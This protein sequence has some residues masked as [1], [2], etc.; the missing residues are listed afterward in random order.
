MLSELLKCSLILLFHRVFAWLILVM[1]SSFWMAPYRLT[2]ADQDR[3]RVLILTDI[4]SL[5]TG[6]AEPDDGQS[7][8][9]LLLYANELQIEGLI[10]S[11]NLGHGQQVRPD[12]I[13]QVIEAYGKVQPNLVKHSPAYPSA[14]HLHQLVKAGQLIAGPKIP[15]T[16]SIGLGQDTEAS[17]WI[18]NVVDQADSRPV[19]VC[20]WGGSADL[21]QAL[22]KVRQTRSAEATQAFVA[23]LRVHTIGDQDTAG[24]WIR[25]EFPTLFYILDRYNYRGMYR[26]GDTK[27]ADSSW[28]ATQIRNPQNPLGMLYPNY[29]GGDIW[30]AKIGRVKGMKEGDSPSFLSLV[31]N[32]LNVPE[33]PEL[34]GWSGFFS[35]N[36]GYYQAWTDSTEASITDP[37]PYMSSVY[38]WRH[39]WQADFVTRLQWC[40]KPYRQAN[41]HP[42]VIVNQNDS[43]QPLQQVV[44]PGAM[45]T[46]NAGKSS[47]PDGHSLRFHWQVYPRS[48]GPGVILTGTNTSQ[49]TCRLSQDTHP[50]TIT[51]LLTVTD[52]GQPALSS[53]RRI[54]LQIQ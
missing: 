24:P 26:G 2:V 47:D 15:I 27:L 9:R 11:S 17:D 53:Y 52:T 25:Q 7:M 21:A 1:I 51:L 14:A 35:R 46:L 6:V 4:T 44:R 8:V 5:Q 13:H 40:I 49:L 22:W 28:V 33:E 23:K 38:R 18:I 43:R 42:I 12:L 30:S 39:D 45:V 54:L 3:L 31:P 41:H 19:W 29:A 37:T 48:E 16:T 50:H 10:A 36:A 34:G 20:A 32:G